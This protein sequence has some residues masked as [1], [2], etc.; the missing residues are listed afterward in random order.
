MKRYSSIGFRSLQLIWLGRLLIS[1][2]WCFEYCLDRQEQRV[3]ELFNNGSLSNLE[4][5]NLSGFYQTV[6]DK[7][8]QRMCLEHMSSQSQTEKH[9]SKVHKNFVFIIAYYKLNTNNIN[10]IWHFL[11]KTK[12]I[13]FQINLSHCYLVTDAGIQW[14]VGSCHSPSLHSLDLSNTDL[15]GNSFLRRLP[16]LSTL[17]LDCCAS[18]SGKP[19]FLFLYVA[20]IQ[21]TIL[22]VQN[23]IFRLY[24]L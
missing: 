12:T 4:E 20:S 16:Q 21:V 8:V 15:T 9:L 2:P 22:N 1:N 6:D 23:N 18:L 19:P 13:T 17:V 24:Y 5:I 10:L 3:D 11:L 14:I 7:L